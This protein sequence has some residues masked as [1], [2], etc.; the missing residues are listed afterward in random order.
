[1]D[2]IDV[3]SLDCVTTDPLEEPLDVGDIFEWNDIPQKRGTV[4]ILSIYVAEDVTTQIRV[5]D[6]GEKR[7]LTVMDV[8]EQLNNGKLRRVSDND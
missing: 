5:D 2:G 1:M 3:D 7:T 4:E 8:L 6:C